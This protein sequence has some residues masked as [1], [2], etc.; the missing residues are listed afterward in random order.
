MNDTILK[1]ALNWFYTL[2][3]AQVDLYLNQAKRCKD[4]YIAR[5]LTKAAEVELKH[6]RGF[7]K[8]ILDLQGHPT[9][10]GELFSFISGFVPGTITPYLGKI[11]QF[12]YNYTLE[13]I[14]IRDYK[15]LISHLEPENETRKMLLNFLVDNLIEEEFH[16][17]WFIDER[18][19]MKKK[20]KRRKK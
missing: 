13:T 20:K 3:L 17:S 15:T 11:A 8:F 12:T 5:I 6:A 10:I 1:L 9:R 2:E 14:A 7:E 16:R 19:K 4:D 18:E